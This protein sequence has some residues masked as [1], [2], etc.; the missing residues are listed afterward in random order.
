MLLGRQSN[1]C[2]WKN[3]EWA[4]S[5]YGRCPHNSI[6][7]FKLLYSFRKKIVTFLFTP[8]AAISLFPLFGV[9]INLLLEVEQKLLRR[10]LV[11]TQKP[12]CLRL[13]S[14]YFLN[15]VFSLRLEWKKDHLDTIKGG[16]GTL[17]CPSRGH[18][19]RP[20]TLSTLRSLRALVEK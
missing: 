13:I 19:W 17:Q 12:D 2:C 5:R 8:I 11:K 1:I 9:P 15:S 10:F 16:R 3:W 7:I 4:L 20:P 6:R 18:Y 14:I